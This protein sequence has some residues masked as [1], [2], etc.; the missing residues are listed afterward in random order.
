MYC[1]V[2]G[3]DFVLTNHVTHFV[4]EYKCKNCKKEFTTSQDGKITLL[5]TKRKEIN[6][7]LNNIHIKK[8]KRKEEVYYDISG[9]KD[10]LSLTSSNN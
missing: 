1:K 8:Q 2:F 6:R 10:N 5:S 7:I 9:W 3:H 4:K